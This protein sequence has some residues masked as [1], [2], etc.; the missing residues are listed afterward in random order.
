M[1]TPKSIENKP[2]ILYSKNT[3]ETTKTTQ[4]R[5]FSI[6]YAEGFVVAVRGRPN[7][8]TFNTSMPSSANPQMKSKLVILEFVYLFSISINY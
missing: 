6:P 7:A 3:D 1:P 2:I 4:S 8:I 5:M